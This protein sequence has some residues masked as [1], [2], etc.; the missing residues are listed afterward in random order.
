MPMLAAAGSSDSANTELP[1]RYLQP[2]RD[3]LDFGTEITFAS[4]HPAVVIFPAHIL[5]KVEVMDTCRSHVIKTYDATYPTDSMEFISIIVQTLR[6]AI[7]PVRG[8]TYIV[9]PMTQR[10]ARAFW[11]TFTGLE[12]MQDTSSEPSMA[13][14]TS[15]WISSAS[16][17]VSL[18]R[19]LNCR[20]L[21]RFG[22][23]SL[24]S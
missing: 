10:F 18:R 14:A 9:R 24:H 16:R 8:C 4:K 21:I 3:L 15:L 7:S 22:K 6:G 17:V 11:Q 20:R 5:E 2:Q 13:T 19:A 12:S 1:E 23:S